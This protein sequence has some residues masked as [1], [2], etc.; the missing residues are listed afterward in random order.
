MARDYER[1]AA[2]I[3]DDLMEGEDDMNLL[4]VIADLPAAVE[5]AALARPSLDIAHLLKW[6]G[7]TANERWVEAWK[8]EHG[9]RQA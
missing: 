3:V 1:R 9:R 7:I 4:A 6:V 2:Q 8:A 5:E